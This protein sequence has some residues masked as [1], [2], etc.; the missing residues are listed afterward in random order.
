MLSNSL[1][2]CE[3]FDNGEIALINE[4]FHEEFETFTYAGL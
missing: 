4:L 2:P 1:D 3:F